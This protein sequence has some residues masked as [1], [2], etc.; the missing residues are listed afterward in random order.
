MTKTRTMLTQLTQRATMMTLGIHDCY[1]YKDNIEIYEADSARDP[2][3][4]ALTFTVD[5]CFGRR[6]SLQS[7]DDHDAKPDPPDASW[8]TPAQPAP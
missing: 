2:K 5:Q 3:A 6:P 1:N 7:Y 4:E 8:S